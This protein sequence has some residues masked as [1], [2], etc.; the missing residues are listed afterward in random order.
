MNQISF[1]ELSCYNFSALV[2]NVLR[3][4]WQSRNFFSCFGAPKKANLLLY[5][6]RCVAEYTLQDGTTLL[7]PPGSLIYTPQ[8]S[9]YKVQIMDLEDDSAGTVGINFFLM[10]ELGASLTI[11]NTV[12]IFPHFPC[13][14]QIDEIDRL[15][16]GSVRN[17]VMIKA[18]FYQILAALCHSQENPLNAKFAVIQKGIAYMEQDP[19]QLLSIKEVAELCDVSEIYFRRLFKEYAGVSPIEYRMHTKIEKAKKY[20]QYDQMNTDEISALLGFT[21]PSYFCRQFKKHTGMTPTE[22]RQQSK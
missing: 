22:Y 11:G 19:R 6:D 13:K 4:H 20:L 8:G 10:D 2:V 9:Q 5:T 15:S 1:S 7:A 12:E 18:V 17:T 14:E 16:N 3:Q 21:D